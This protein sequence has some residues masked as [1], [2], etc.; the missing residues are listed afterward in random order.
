MAIAVIKNE[1][2][3]GIDICPYCGSENLGDVPD[4]LLPDDYPDILKCFDCNNTWEMQTQQI[5]EPVTEG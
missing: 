1:P 3:P 5:V 2:K 4:F